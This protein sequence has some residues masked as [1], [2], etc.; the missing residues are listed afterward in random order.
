MLIPSGSLVPG[1]DPAAFGLPAGTALRYERPAESLRLLVPSYAVLDSDPAIW[2]G[3]DSWVLPGW[4]QLWV[5]LTSGTVT[6]RT[7]KR[8]PVSLGSAMLYG[9]TSCAMPVTSQ[10]G[11]TVVIDLSPAGWARW[12]DQPADAMRDQIMPIGSGPRTALAS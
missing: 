7:R 3:P 5:V 9:G 8:Q 1:I 6:V 2:M 12:F 4:P 11:V 10:G